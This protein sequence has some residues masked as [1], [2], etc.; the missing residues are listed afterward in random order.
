MIIFIRYGMNPASWGNQEAKT[1]ER[2]LFMNLQPLYDIKERLEHAAIAGTGLLLE[3]FRLKRAVE[4]LAPLSA[5]IP[6]FAKISANVEQLLNAPEEKQSGMLLDA[7]A[8]VDAVAYTQGVTNLD[9]ELQEL[10]AHNGYY[11]EVSYGQLRPLLEA[12]CTTGGGRMALVEETWNNHPEYFKDYRVLPALIEDL[13]DKYKELAD[14]NEKILK[15]FGAEVIPALKTGFQ[16]AGKS[17]MV[18]RVR[19]LDKIAGAKE[20]DFYL[21]QLPKSKKEI[22]ESLIFALRHDEKNIEKLLELCHTEKGFAKEKALQALACL[23]NP[24]VWDYFTSLEEKNR[25]KNE[26]STS[27]CRSIAPS[28]IGSRSQKAGEFVNRLVLQE[29]EPF[30]KDPAKTIGAEQNACLQSL[31]LAVIGKPGNTVAESYLAAAAFCKQKGFT[32]RPSSHYYWHFGNY[33]GIDFGNYQVLPTARW[34][35]D[36]LRYSIEKYFDFTLVE[37]AAK[38]YETYG[39]DY[40]APALVGKLLTEDAGTCFEWAKEQYNKKKIL[41]Q[42]TC[43][44]IG[45]QFEI[46]FSHLYWDENKSVYQFKLHNMQPVPAFTEEK[47]FGEGCVPLYQPLDPRWYELFTENTAFFSIL[48][49]LLQN[50]SGRDLSLEKIGPCLYRHSLSEKAYYDTCLEILIR[51]GW[52]DWKGYLCKKANKTGVLN[53]HYIVRFL[54]KVPMTNLERAEE[55]KEVDVLAWSHKVRTEP[56]DWFGENLT[57]LIRWLEANPDADMPDNIYYR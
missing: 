4:N 37:L 49:Q 46:A 6:V 12:L 56:N 53:S 11:C 51:L 2:I 16:P 47:V 8:L 1:S 52:K 40:L 55:L 43:K 5:A 33:L 31:F 44:K 15:E 48:I 22:R 3:D 41:G 20:N 36:T 26:T 17:D 35:A 57:N 24:K 32:N 9:G 29:I 39:E 13:G 54:K 19:I 28:L 27:F 34:L 38:L 21:E 18:R 7:L 50:Y 42:K 10:P 45:E 30:L 23:D 14:L 25:K